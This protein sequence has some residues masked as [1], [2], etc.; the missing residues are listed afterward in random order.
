ML[1][2]SFLWNAPA[3]NSAQQ[4]PSESLR[5]EMAAPLEIQFRFRIA[6]LN[7]Y[8]GMYLYRS[9]SHRK[10]NMKAGE[11]SGKR[12]LLKTCLR[13]LFQI[14]ASTPLPSPHL[15]HAQLPVWVYMVES[16]VS[17]WRSKLVTWKS[18]QTYSPSA[19]QTWHKWNGKMDSLSV[20][21]T[22]FSV[23]KWVFLA[24][25]NNW[26]ILVGNFNFL[27]IHWERNVALK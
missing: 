23:L 16:Q 12:K 9:G 15:P 24:W 14:T 21:P 11:G 2:A 8:L 18:V 25:K 3:L 20:S 4:T 26:M 17:R 7:L 27:K 19:T 5:S 1:I 22:R 6:F 10:R 13:L